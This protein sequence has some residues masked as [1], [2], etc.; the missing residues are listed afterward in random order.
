VLASSNNAAAPDSMQQ[1]S[2][3]QPQQPASA[4]SIARQ[5]AASEAA[6]GT[7]HQALGQGFA[8]ATMPV[9]VAGATT[10]S[11]GSPGRRTASEMPHQRLKYKLKRTEKAKL[12][13]MLCSSHKA[14][15]SGD[16][17][18]VHW[19]S[20][21]PSPKP[22]TADA[23]DLLRVLLMQPCFMQTGIISRLMCSSKAASTAI[24]D[25]CT[26]HI[27]AHLQDNVPIDAAQQFPAWMVKHG[28]LLHSLQLGKGRQGQAAVIAA[29]LQAAAAMNSLCLQQFHSTSEDTSSLGF[30]SLMPPAYLT[31]LQL[32][33][34]NG[35]DNQQMAAAI[36]QL[37]H[38]RS[39]KITSLK[40]LQPKISIGGVSPVLY[41]LAHLKQL[42]SLHLH[43]SLS[44]GA[45]SII[46]EQLPASLIELRITGATGDTCCLGQKECMPVQQL[47]ASPLSQRGH[48]TLLLI[49]TGY[50]VVAGRAA[51][52]NLGHLTKLTALQMEC[53][54][55][56][57]AVTYVDTLPPQLQVVSLRCCPSL[58]PLEGMM[59]LRVLT[60]ENPPSD[61]LLLLK[62]LMTGELP[63]PQGQPIYCTG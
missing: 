58:Q 56:G 17:P 16:V 25:I 59:Q 33:L 55:Q 20:A 26:G 15:F 38:L 41:A 61:E 7:S 28:H 50:A 18:D 35:R 62:L 47:N 40:A 1:A 5:H 60:L 19:G 10:T 51:P 14:A 45:A 6:A 36:L 52:I 42:S 8:V 31:S 48:S 30:I 57:N 3:V 13:L 11:P 44:G 29:G 24:D 49:L 43:R 63:W 23:D 4:L 2:I 53:S 21:E 12:D 37:Q 39:L 34:T 54:R 32:H 22:L 9:F 27:P 46:L